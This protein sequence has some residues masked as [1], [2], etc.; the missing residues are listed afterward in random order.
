[1]HVAGEIALEI[2]V[3]RAFGIA[4]QDAFDVSDTSGLKKRGNREKCEKHE[5]RKS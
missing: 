1:V 4:A 5:Y 2:A 3:Q